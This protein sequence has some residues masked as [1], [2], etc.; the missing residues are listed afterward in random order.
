MELWGNQVIFS[1]WGLWYNILLRL[2]TDIK[3]LHSLT[4]MYI[5]T[6]MHNQDLKHNQ[7]KMTSQ[8]A[9]MFTSYRDGSINSVCHFSVL[10]SSH[11]SQQ[12]TEK[13]KKTAMANRCRALTAVHVHVVETRKKKKIKKKKKKKITSFYFLWATMAS[14]SQPGGQPCQPVRDEGGVGFSKKPS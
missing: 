12:N 1:L 10:A 8:G 7:D 11:S 5:Y 6:C 14:T 13:V 4:H 2:Q 9:Q 3:T